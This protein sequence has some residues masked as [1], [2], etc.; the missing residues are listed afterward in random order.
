[1]LDVAGGSGVLSFELVNLNN[2]ESTVIDPRPLRLQKSQKWLRHGWYHRNAFFQQYV[3]VPLSAFQG[4]CIIRLPPHIPM[5][6]D[7]DV[8]ACLTEGQ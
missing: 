4:S 6:L 3:D 7:Y 8:I 5:V 1:M 2:L